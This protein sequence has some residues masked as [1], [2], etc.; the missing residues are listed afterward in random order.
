MTLCWCLVGLY[1]KL[2]CAVLL[3]D[4]FQRSAVS[5]V[6]VC[7]L[8]ARQLLVPAFEIVCTDPLS[9]CTRPQ[10]APGHYG[11][12]AT[13]PA[14]NGH[15][16]F[17]WPNNKPPVAATTANTSAV[18]VGTG[19][20]HNTSFMLPFFIAYQCAS[21]VRYYLP[22]DHTATHESTAAVVSLNSTGQNSAT[23]DTC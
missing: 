19:N 10:S 7:C 2:C 3:N 4:R 6:Y 1:K 12:S 11:S 18:V 23:M 22:G 9:F 17:T 8:I 5:C 13:A 21:T 15:P 20:A 14:P 16:Q